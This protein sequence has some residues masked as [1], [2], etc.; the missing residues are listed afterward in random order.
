MTLN[1]P[2]GKHGD[3]HR[4]TRLKGYTETYLMTV[5]LGKVVGGPRQMQSGEIELSMNSQKAFTVAN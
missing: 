5:K 3:V 2:T 1:R 4:V